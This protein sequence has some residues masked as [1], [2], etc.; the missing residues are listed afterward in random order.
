LR[1][2][3]IPAVFLG[4]RN[5]YLLTEAKTDEPCLVRST[6]DPL[7]SIADTLVL[8]LRDESR[9]ITLSEEV[10]RKAL[11]QLGA[12]PEARGLVRAK[13]LRNALEL[14]TSE[15]GG[16]LVLIIDQAEEVFTLSPRGEDEP[17]TA[18][19]QFLE[20]LCFDRFDIKIMGLRDFVWVNRAA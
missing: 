17:R 7:A 14:I 18:Y 10:R 6:A 13:S 12:G 19:F 9:F 20:G 2:G 16:T 1:A 5:F 4:K 3:L 11:D 8:Q 15:L